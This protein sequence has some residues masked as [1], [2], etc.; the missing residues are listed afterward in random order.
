MSKLTPT[1]LRPVAAFALLAWLAACSQQ[2]SPTPAASTPPPTDPQSAAQA[3]AADAA[4][5]AAVAASVQ[6]LS[7][8]ADAA[9]L[10]EAGFHDATLFF[11]AF[12]WRGW[13]AHA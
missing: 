8:E 12:T 7:P 2:P 13:I 6:M 10:D 9:I 11:A 3:V 1:A 5:K 4:P